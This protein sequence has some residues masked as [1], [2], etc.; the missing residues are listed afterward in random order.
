LFYDQIHALDIEDLRHAVSFDQF[1]YKALLEDS[2]DE[3]LSGTLKTTLQGSELEN[4]LKR[5]NLGFYV[6]KISSSTGSGTNQITQPN[7][8]QRYYSDV[9]NANKQVTQK[10]TIN[11]KVLG[12][13][14]SNWATSDAVTLEVLVPFPTGTVIGTAAPIARFKRVNGG[15]ETIEIVTGTLSGGI[16]ASKT[17]TLGNNTAVGLTDQDIYITFEIDYPQKGNKLTKPL[18]E[19][20]RV[21]DVYNNKEWGFLSVNDYDDTSSFPYRRE[22]KVPYRKTLGYED[23]GYTYS[24]QSGRN[25]HG[26]GTLVSYFLE[27]NGTQEYTIPGSL[28]NPQDLEYVL[29]AYD[30]DNAS[31]AYMD[32]GYVVRNPSNYSIDVSLPYSISA[33][34]AIRFDV[35]VSGGIL[36]YDE[37]TQSVEDMGKLDWYEITGERY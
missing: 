24:I 1:N 8:Q 15:V 11:D 4:S 37:R 13:S 25:Y 26:I 30:V 36:E 35:V 27:G 29:A 23:Y 20:L 19:V 2:F 16:S 18:T 28:I 14:G 12:V 21:H 33:G 5:T 22:A 34:R 32:F 7:G 9:A 17:F 31:P 6:N 3:L 10:F